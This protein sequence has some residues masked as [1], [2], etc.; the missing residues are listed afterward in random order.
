MST[1]AYRYSG[2]VWIARWD[3]A[4]TTTPLMPN[5][6]NSW[7]TTS[8]MVAWARFAASTRAPLTD[9]RLLM[10]SRSQSN[11]SSKRCRPRAFNPLVPLSPIRPS[12]APLLRRSALRRY[13]SKKFRFFYKTCF[14]VWS[15]LTHCK[16]KTHFLTPPTLP[17]LLSARAEASGERGRRT[18]TASRRAWQVRDDHADAGN[19][20][21]ASAA[22]GRRGPRGLRAR[23]ASERARVETTTRHA[24]AAPV[25]L[26]SI[27]A[28]HVRRRLEGTGRFDPGALARR[29][30]PDDA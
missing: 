16:K 2:Q 9:S 30:C 18:R 7:K 27:R 11:I 25:R 13:R 12:T 21:R 29:T 26:G 15:V 10:A 17:E 20:R 14:T 28:R 1:A 23:A 6:L 8:T 3:S 24:S 5:G 4:M 19:A 22:A